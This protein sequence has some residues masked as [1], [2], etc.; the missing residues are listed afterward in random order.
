MKIRIKYFAGLRDITGRE[1]ETIDVK[2]KTRIA[3]ILKMVYS[4][5][6]DMRKTAE[7]IVARNRQY[8]DENERV[9]DGDEIALLPPVSGG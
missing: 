6:P 5:Y 2:E 4:K 8:A 9:E 1:S 7:I 3:D